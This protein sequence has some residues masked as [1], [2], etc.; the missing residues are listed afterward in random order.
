MVGLSEM[1]QDSGAG[2][3]N[4]KRL[5]VH[6]SS[7][8]VALPTPDIGAQFTAFNSCKNMSFCMSHWYL[9]DHNNRRE[10]GEGWK[11]RK[12][13]SEKDRKNFFLLAYTVDHSHP[14]VQLGEAGL[15]Y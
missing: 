13:E 4:S 3:D 6:S 7:Q 1:R 10:D 9:A 14:G 5:C 8:K 12:V 2:G 15:F 11:G